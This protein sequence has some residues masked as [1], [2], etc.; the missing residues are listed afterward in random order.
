MLSL[1]CG[2]S[3]SS[4]FGMLCRVAGSFANEPLDTCRGWK[5]LKRR[6]KVLFCLLVLMH[7]RQGWR[8]GPV[9][10]GILQAAL[11]SLSFHLSSD[12]ETRQAATMSEYVMTPG[13][14]SEYAVSRPFAPCRL[15]SAYI[16]SRYSQSAA[17]PVF[18]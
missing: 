9:G 4:E 16:R 13:Q 5:R 17:L 6:Y 14:A 10:T 7:N 2:F 11:Q 15:R 18:I 8:K 12:K 3:T 1:S